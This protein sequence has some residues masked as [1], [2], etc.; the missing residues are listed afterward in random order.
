VKAPVRFLLVDLQAIGF[1]DLTG[2]D[3][4]KRLIETCSRRKVRVAFMSIHAPV[5]ETFRRSG[6]VD[7]VDRDFLIANRGEAIGT[8]FA[9]L[10]HAYCR[11]FCPYSLFYE[12]AAK[13]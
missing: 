1:I 3:E 7:A 9:E 8:L 13:K 2:I 6:L 4:L 11:D 5:M 12:C 10:D